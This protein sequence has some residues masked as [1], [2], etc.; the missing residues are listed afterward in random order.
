MKYKKTFSAVVFAV[1]AALLLSGCAG[2]GASTFKPSDD[3]AEPAESSETAEQLE[4]SVISSAPDNTPEISADVSPSESPDAST[5]PEGFTAL[6]E[7]ELEWFNTEYFNTYPNIHNQFV[8]SLYEKPEDINL[9]DT[10][11][12]GSGIDDYATEE[13]RAAIVEAYGWDMEPDCSCQKNSVAA[14]D[15]A[16]TE[17]MGLTLDK[18]NGNGLDMMLYLPEYDAYYFYHGDTNYLGVTV[19]GGCRDNAGG[20]YLNYTCVTFYESE[21]LLHLEENGDG[22]LFVSNIEISGPPGNITAG[23]DVPDEVVGKAEELVQQWFRE[24]RAQFPGCRYVNWRITSLEYDYTYDDFDGMTLQIYRMNYEYYSETPDNVVLVGGMYITDYNWVMPGY[25][26]CTY[27]IF[28]EDGGERTYLKAMME[29][30]CVPGDELFTSDLTRALNTP[31]SLTADTSAGIEVLLDYADD[32]IVVFHGY[33]GVFVYDLNANRIRSAVDFSKTLGCTNVNG[34][35]IVSVTVSGDG[36]TVQMYLSG[37]ESEMREMGLDPDV[38]WYLDTAGGV[39][40]KG[41]YEALENAFDAL[42]PANQPEA[43]SFEGVQFPDGMAYIQ[44]GGNTL[45]DLCYVRAD[46]VWYLL[47]NYFG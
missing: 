10:F 45:G 42:T 9:F 28:S 5:V 38:A 16:L 25:P 19:T 39:L 18:T 23:A 31:D 43:G 46:K 1:C 35:V 14:M 47:D 24:D 29:N 26:D 3:D 36:K 15:A 8:I 17:N 11:Y 37:V 21:R 20:V 32:N 6:S 41:V 12:I 2:F 40:R 34:S 27:L 22:Y 33:F 4:D 13:E 30:D 44:Y 7:E